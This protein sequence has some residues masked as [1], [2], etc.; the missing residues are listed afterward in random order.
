MLW[1]KVY[2]ATSCGIKVDGATTLKNAA[3]I[4]SKAY[5]SPK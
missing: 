1:V 2:G 3:K 5:V 4:K